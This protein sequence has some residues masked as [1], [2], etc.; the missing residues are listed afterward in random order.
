MHH[1]L[2]LPVDGLQDYHP[3]TLWIYIK[4]LI[5]WLCDKQQQ[6]QQQKQSGLGGYFL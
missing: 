2:P 3:I 1:C 5:M 6:Q 4:V